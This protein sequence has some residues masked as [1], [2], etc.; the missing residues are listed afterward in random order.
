MRKS[1]AKYGMMMLLSCLFT[2]IVSAQ[3]NTANI[4]R[5]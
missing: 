2:L 3:T 1:I 4:V 5:G